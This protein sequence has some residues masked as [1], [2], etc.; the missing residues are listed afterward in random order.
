MKVVFVTLL[1]VA[2]AW[3]ESEP[4]PTAR[5]CP[6]WLV[7]CPWLVNK[8]AN[9]DGPNVPWR[10][11]SYERGT[12]VNHGGPIPP[13]VRNFFDWNCPVWDPNCNLSMKSAMKCYWHNGERFCEPSIR[14]HGQ[15]DY[16]PTC[17]VWNQNC[18]DSR[19][20]KQSR[21]SCLWLTGR[22]C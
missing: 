8:P 11:K 9:Y 10:F 6:P 2:S 5:F 4:R 7:Y 20:F 22:P 17:P 16:D 21:A 18:H 1:I 12:G 3:A 15:F 14:R 19:D 13:T